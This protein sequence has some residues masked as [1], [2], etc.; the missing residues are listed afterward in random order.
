MNI[1]N[2]NVVAKLA[3]VVAG[4]GLVAMSFAPVAKADTASDLQAQIAS[5]LAQISSLQSQLGTSQGSSASVT[6]SRDLTLGSTG[7]DVTALQNWLISKGF[8][9]SAGAT[10]YFGAQTK[11]S[12]AAYQ[13]ANAISPAAGYFGPVTRAK[14][15]ASAGGSTSTDGGTSTG[16]LSG[17]EASF[18]NYSLVSG[19]DLSEGDSNSEIAVAKFTVKNGDARVQRVTVE[20]TG[21]AS[22]AS[23][24]KL[25][26]KFIDTLSVYNGSKKVG[27]VDAGS[28]SDW[29]KDGNTYSIDIPVDSVVREDDKV[30]L[31]IRADAQSTIDSTDETQVFNLAIPTDGI[32]AV[33][34]K[35]IQEYVGNGDDVSLGFNSADSG[36]LVVSKASDNPSAGVLVADDTD[37]SSSF[38]V[39]KFKIRNKD[40]ADVTL[41]EL[42]FDVATSS[43]ATTTGAANIA[44]IIRK[45]TLDLD[46]QTY[47][48]TVGTTTVVFDDMDADISADDSV[49][50][51]LSIT[52]FGQNNHY[53]ASGESLTFSL[54]G[55]DTKVDAEGADTGDTSSVSGSAN[56]ENQA[57]SVDAGINVAGTSDNAVL[58]YNSNDTTKSYGTYTL[59]FD[60]TADGDDIFVPKTVASTSAASTTAG[61]VIDTSINGAFSGTSTASMSTT[62][63]SQNANYYVVHDGDTETFTVT[64]T[65]DPS[66]T[67][68]FAVG[69]DQVRFATD[70]S[71][72]TGLQTLEIDQTKSEFKTDALS[73]QN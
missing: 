54:A 7:T 35:G 37:T 1:A 49:D 48:G 17:G 67:G 16:G 24:S 41:N 22:S 14:V 62:A 56:G 11:A 64:Y 58:T 12:L 5:L 43:A 13:A 28:K 18:T 27:D 73:I 66:A 36:D 30:E 65:L 32:R 34:S 47:T 42:T 19:D 45:A 23:V 50:G 71:T 38:D 69:L 61:V 68:T 33:D 63:D 25:P 55:N 60:V 31:S 10:G 8:A 72:L 40:N 29:D 21:T 46:G 6:F 53:A 15:N 2:S 26:W 70:S 3:A 57:I 39:L 52:L 9:I 20:L 51:T 4:L 59:K 44:S